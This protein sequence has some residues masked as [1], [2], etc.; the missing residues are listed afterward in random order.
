MLTYGLPELHASTSSG[1][2][3]SMII[4]AYNSVSHSILVHSIY[5]LYQC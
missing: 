4:L 2:T 1:P 3:S 5:M